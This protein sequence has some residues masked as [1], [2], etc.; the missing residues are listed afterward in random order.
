MNELNKYLNDTISPSELETLRAKVDAMSDA[1]LE[2]ELQSLWD[3]GVISTD[4]VSADL[5]SSM[6]AKIFSLI[7]EEE[8]SRIAE[9][10]RRRLR[11]RHI[12]HAVRAVLSVA[13]VLLIAFLAFVSYHF[14]DQ[15]VQLADQ[16]IIFSTA[17]EERATITL[18][19]GTSVILNENSRLSYSPKTYTNNIRNVDFD[20]EGFFSVKK[21]T[22]CPFTIYAKG[23]NIIDMGTKFNLCARE[24]KPDA[25]LYLEEGAVEFLS[26]ATG[27]YENLLPGEKA[28]LDRKDGSI[29]VIKKVDSN[30]ENA[31]INHQIVL[32]DCSFNDIIRH[33]EKTYGMKVVTSYCPKATDTFTGTMPSD[34]LDEALTIVEMI[35]HVKAN[36]KG[37]KIYIAQ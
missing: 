31:W 19:D 13:A 23:L 17:A 4:N 8:E 24:K 30:Q 1:D 5:L 9:I 14:Y 34:D 36:V 27:K 6:K 37:R 32:Q 15:N 33:I 18:P 10:T 16:N 2:E 26:T 3:D 20:G 7:G 35:Y 29:T 12:R 28:I 11:M 22:Q 25:F 21:K